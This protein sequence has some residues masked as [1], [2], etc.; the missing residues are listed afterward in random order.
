MWVLPAKKTILLK[1]TEFAGATDGPKWTC[2]QD[3]KGR[4]VPSATALPQ[5]SKKQPKFAISITGLQV[6]YMDASYGE[7][8][9][10]VVAFRRQTD[11][12]DFNRTVSGFLVR[13][14]E[15]GEVLEED[16]SMAKKLSQQL[17][18][19]GSSNLGTKRNFSR[20]LLS[21]AM[22]P[23]GNEGGEGLVDKSDKQIL[24][25]VN[26]AIQEEDD[27]A[28][29]DDMGGDVQLFCNQCMES[30]NTTDLKKKKL[31]GMKRYQC[32]EGHLLE[33]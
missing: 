26:S 28:E 25:M 15:S 10:I 22:R 24:K 29:E 30:Y 27:D 17:A 5:H 18:K 31:D 2:K 7:E 12:S 9:E 33:G 16:A 1:Q 23:R 11:M 8:R 6:S 4:L 20:K 21:L 3:E 14:D 32:P 19:T 13:H